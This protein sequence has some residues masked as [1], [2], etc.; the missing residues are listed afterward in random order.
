[1]GHEAD[2]GS[3]IL[4]ATDDDDSG[5]GQG[6]HC[7]GGSDGPGRRGS[8]LRPAVAITP[9]TKHVEEGQEESVLQA[10]STE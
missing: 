5:D 1:M 4:W 10:L 8:I 9:T 7:A 6:M 3:H 2:Y